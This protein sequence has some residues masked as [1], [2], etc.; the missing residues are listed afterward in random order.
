MNV[1][2]AITIV[3]HHALER[4]EEQE[5]E[6]VPGKESDEKENSTQEKGT[7]LATFDAS[8]DVVYKV[9]LHMESTQ[10]MCHTH[11]SLEGQ[12]QHTSVSQSPENITLRGS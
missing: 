8:T 5:N 9:N 7:S 4:I 10:V 11:W 3:T 12:C 2:I 1:S 6:S